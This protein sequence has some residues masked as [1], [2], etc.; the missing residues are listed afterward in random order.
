MSEVK[1]LEELKAQLEGVHHASKEAKELKK[2]IEEMEGVAGNVHEKEPE[3]KTK[4]EKK[5]LKKM[6]EDL[7]FKIN[8]DKTYTFQLQTESQG[9][10]TLPKQVKVWDE[11][12]GKLRTIRYSK[13]EE[14]PYLDEQDEGAEMERSEVKFNKGLLVVSGRNAPLINYLLAF[15][16]NSEKDKINPS[17]KHYK[18][19][20]RLENEGE[21][22]RASKEKRESI[23]KAMNV[24][25][26]ASQEDLTAFL[27]SQFRFNPESDIKVDN[28]EDALYDKAY[29]YAQSK[30]DVFI[31]DFNNPRHKI[32]SDLQQAFE[33]QV[34]TIDNKDV[35]RWKSTSGEIL[36]YDSSKVRAD[37]ALTVWA[38]SSKEGKEFI[39]ELQVKL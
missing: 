17:N 26:D 10:V 37:E 24:V 31:E 18:G 9:Q 4:S 21:K 6:E 39:K 11:A 13:T 23:R 27:R 14:S 12:K 25:A 2:Q 38:L 16:G 3:V 28:K 35:I 32:K 15:D 36:K 30:P 20:Y 29:A 19:M 33:K 1:T 8:P 34:L 5:I 22:V 7:D